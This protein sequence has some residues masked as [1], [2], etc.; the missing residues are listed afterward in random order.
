[1]SDRI[2]YHTTVKPEWLDSNGHMNDAYYA[3]AFSKALD[4]LID[5]LGMDSAYRSKTA[6]SLF[7]LQAQICYLKEALLGEAMYADF[8]MLGF[9]RKRLH[10]FFNLYRQSDQE[11]LATSEQMLLH[12]DMNV[13]RGASF[14]EFIGSKILSLWQAHAGLPKPHQAGRGYMELANKL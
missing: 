11:L 8:Q 6:R 13:R 7:T 10:L 2:I 14:D 5:D 1:M 9:D 12:V 4:V 3:I